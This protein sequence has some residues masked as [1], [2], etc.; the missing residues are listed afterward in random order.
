VLG[1]KASLIKTCL[2]ASS[3]FLVEPFSFPVTYVDP[4]IGGK[5]V[6]HNIAQQFAWQR[7]GADE[8]IFLIVTS[9]FV[10]TI[11][12]IVNAT[13]TC[14]PDPSSRIRELSGCCDAPNGVSGPYACNVAT[15]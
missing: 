8:S 7:L 15:I 10:T 3:N 13:I 4:N 1:H 2:D 14:L 6:G 12:S 5:I 9:I 11:V